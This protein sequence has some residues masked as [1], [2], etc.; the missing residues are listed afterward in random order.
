MKQGFGKIRFGAIFPALL[1]ALTNI[2]VLWSAVIVFGG[3]PIPYAPA[4]NDTYFEELWYLENLD[5]DAVR[6]GVDMNA[7]SAWSFSRGAGVTIAIVDDGVDLSHPELT[8]RAVPELHWNFA[9][10]TPDGNHVIDQHRHG[11][12]VA[13][14]AV[15][16]AN[17]GRGVVGIAPEANF[18]SWV[19][20][21]TNQGGSSFVPGPQ[22]AKMFEFHMDEVEVQNHSWVKPGRFLARMTPEENLAISNA[23]VN[24]RDGRGVVMVRGVG[25]GRADTRNANYDEYTA[26]PRVI[27]VAANRPDGRVASY[28]TP[29]APILVAALGGEGPS[30]LMTTDRVAQKGYNQIFFANDLADYVFSGF[31]F[32]GT[33]AA[34]PLV[35]GVVALMLSEN[36]ELTVRDVQHILVQSAFHSDLEDADVRVT[37]AGL[38]VSHNLGFGQVNGGTALELAANWKLIAPAVRVT[39]RIERTSAIPDAALKVQ[40]SASGG[41]QGSAIALPSFG[42]HSDGETGTLPLVHVGLATNRI[43]TNLAGKAALIQRGVTTFYEKI[44]NAA[45]AG[46]EFAVIYNNAGT[47]SLDLMVGTEMVTIPAVMITQE[48]G[49]ELAALATNENVTAAITQETATY[50]FNITEPLIAEHVRV[51]VDA[52]HQ[53]RGDMR[54]TL[55]SPMGTRSV[56]HQLNPDGS[57]V[58]EKWTYMTTHH[59]YESPIGTWRLYFSDEGQGLTGEVRSAAVEITGIRITDS[60]A[61]GLD[62]GWEQ[63]NLGNLA[64][65]LADDPDNDGYSNAREQIQGTQPHV[66]D[67]VLAVDL[68]AWKEGRIRLNWPARNGVEF[69]VLA[70]P[71]LAQPFEVLA[72]ITGGFPRAAWIGRVDAKYKFF[73]VREL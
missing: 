26:D 31:G 23:V 5:S 33:S 37:P 27:T 28:S 69:E 13:G 53:W 32:I 39:N 7:R 65:G 8:N 70:T 45:R 51:E 35:S 41:E 59:F 10:D 47:N 61:D 19:I 14:L 52:T 6:H 25:N 40:Y 72:T 20:Y 18:A 2:L 49:E 38:R 21:H 66:N 12:P 56:L 60:E 62:D 67:S 11:T 58:N 63:A 73:T 64:S 48:D 36:P 1:K 24:G 22:L 29:G 16:E 43:T 9:T 30:S 55:V 50:E 71:D 57:P 54:V 42:I 3:E 4:P 46:A 34:A 15:A 17:N 44:E 68:S